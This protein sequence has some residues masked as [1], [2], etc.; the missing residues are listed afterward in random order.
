MYNL[1]L[2][3]FTK[4][5][6]LWKNKG[7]QKMYNLVLHIFTPHSFKLIHKWQMV[8]SLLVDQVLKMMPLES[9][10][11]DLPLWLQILIYRLVMWLLLLW[12]SALLPSKCLLVDTILYDFLNAMTSHIA[13]LQIWIKWIKSP[14]PVLLWV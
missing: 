7:Y 1:V 3:I 12:V 5:L 6:S 4:S 14:H 8:I 13:N 9:Y 2:H 10:F 11:L